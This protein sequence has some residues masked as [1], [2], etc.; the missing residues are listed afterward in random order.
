MI[1]ALPQNK[2]RHMPR[3]AKLPFANLPPRCIALL[4]PHTYKPEQALTHKP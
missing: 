3:T 4:Q 2:R 1:G